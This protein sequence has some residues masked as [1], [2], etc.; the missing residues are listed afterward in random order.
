MSLVSASASLNKQNI[1]PNITTNININNASAKP[2]NVAL[3]KAVP[4]TNM[5]DN[6]YNVTESLPVEECTVSTD[7]QPSAPPLSRDK[8]SFSD[9]PSGPSIMSEQ[10][11]DT[12]KTD[13]MI[14]Y[15][16]ILH[17]FFT[18]KKKL[19]V[20]LLHISNNIIL[21]KQELIRLISILTGSA[22]VK[23]D[24]EPVKSGCCF[25]KK[26]YENI[27]KII[28][29]GMDFWISQNDLFNYLREYVCVDKC[30]DDE[31]IV[32]T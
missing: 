21:S 20:H 25:G 24:S 16:K 11:V 27:T 3:G 17:N 19:L 8:Y 31:L 30:F 29:D 28:V 4:V 2:R 9:Y 6:A 5:C 7:V 15:S 14:E 22:N 26:L 10:K 23:I 13:F 18:N 1:T 12:R 32:A